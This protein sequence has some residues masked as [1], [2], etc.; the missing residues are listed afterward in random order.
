M[1]FVN[2][3][4]HAI[5]LHTAKEVCPMCEITGGYCDNCSGAHWG[6]QPV[7]V[8]PPSGI[9]PRCSTVRK[10]VAPIAGVRITVQTVGDVV[11][12]PPAEEGVALIVSAMVLSA[13]NGT[14]ADVFAPDTGADAVR[15]NGQI[16]AVRGLVQ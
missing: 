2:C 4:P 1:K 11:G 16:V 5:T 10:E 8:L 6:T 13:L 12:L 15:E 14:R 7:M 9:L 3:T